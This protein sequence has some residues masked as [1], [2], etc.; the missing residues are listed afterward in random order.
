MENENTD[1]N[2]KAT[3]LPTKYEVE[4]TFQLKKRSDPNSSTQN[5]FLRRPKL[6]AVVCL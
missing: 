2:T 1:G 4:P 6:L 5:Y 3:E